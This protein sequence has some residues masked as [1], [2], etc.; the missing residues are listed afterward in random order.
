MEYDD[1]D[2]TDDIISGD[3][4]TDDDGEFAFTIAI[5]ESA[6]GDHTIT[7]TGED[8]DITAS[9]DFEV[10]PKITIAPDSGKR[11][12][13][14]AITGTGFP[15]DEDITITFD[16]AS[17]TT[18]PLSVESDS[19]GS[20]SASFVVPNSSGGVH[21]VKASHGTYDD[22]ASF[23][24]S[25]TLTLDQT[26]GYI[27][28][29]V[30][31]SGTGFQAG[32]PVT[33]YF[34]NTSV[35]ANVVN[36]NGSVSVSFTVPSH[37]AGTFKVRVTDQTNSIELDFQILTSAEI[38]QT[39][40]HIGTELTA[41]GVG[42]TAGRTVTVKYD[43]TQITSTTVQPDGSF[44]IT[45]GV[46]VS[47]GGQHVITV[48]DTI[49]TQQFAFVIESTP[50]STVFAQLPLM[51]SKL[52]DWRFDWSGNRNDLTQEVT[53]D[54]LPVTYTLQIATDDSFSANSIVLEKTGLT[55]SEYTLTKE[56][57][58]PSVDQESPYHWRVR[59]I[60]AASNATAWTGTG[61]F[62]V[63][64]SFSIPQPVIYT[65]FGVGALLLGVLG[66]WLG[67]KTAYY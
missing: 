4:E 56:E 37:A 16:G 7:V 9:A 25:A 31:V 47:T 11:N 10:E 32:Q 35:A 42:F 50:P 3:T 17:V 62:Y 18:S 20:F 55:E 30:N 61:S 13:T 23:I 36:T 63:G 8:S 66:F 24:V 64:F 5:P 21:T 14:I 57:R 34:D 54:S 15:D 22:T 39:S 46:P 29:E 52:A 40:G 41:S 44:S 2:I 26:T 67:R 33:V 45:F 38:S 60:D 6:T 48:S 58:L 59:A 65:L 19:D 51:D 12:D 28:T 43:G 27:G 1:D 53:D 49:I